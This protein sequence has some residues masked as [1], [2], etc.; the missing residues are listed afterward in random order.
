MTPFC[1]FPNS[2]KLFGI[3]VRVLVMSILPDIDTDE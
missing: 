2:R 3:S 1:L